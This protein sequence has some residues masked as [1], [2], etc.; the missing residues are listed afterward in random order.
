MGDPKGSKGAGGQWGP[1]TMGTDGRAGDTGQ[2]KETGTVTVFLS[3]YQNGVDKKGRVSVPASFRHEMAA[4]TRQQVVV[5]A[6]P[7]A[8]SNGGYLYGWAYDDFVKLA[9]KIQQLPALSPVRQRL[10]RAVLAAA[11]PLS[12]DD[13]GRIMLP[14]NLMSVAGLDG[15][16]LFAGQGEYFTIWNPK[17]FDAQMAADAANRTEDLSELEKV[18]GL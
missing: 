17:R 13:A 14:E 10:A 5:Y 2:T 4:H 8:G 6:A 18:W 16:A 9:E 12:F 3:S 11:R 1:P 7:D 15:D